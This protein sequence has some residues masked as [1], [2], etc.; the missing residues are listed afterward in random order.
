MGGV[1]IG[2]GVAALSPPR[3]APVLTASQRVGQEKLGEI[4]AA[5]N[6]PYELAARMREHFRISPAGWTLKRLSA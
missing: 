3:E 2:A 5:S 6:T 1:R 4:F